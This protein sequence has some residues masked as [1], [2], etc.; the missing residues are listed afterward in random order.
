M[1]KSRTKAQGTRFAVVDFE[2]T[3]A[4]PGDRGRATEIGLVIIEDGQIVDQ[5]ESLMWTGAPI[6]ERIQ[7]L[8]GITP[9]MLDSAPKAADVMREAC[10]RVGD[11]CLIAHNAGFDRG[12]W[13]EEC[14]LAELEH[15]EPAFL[16]TLKLSRRIH[17]E[18]PRHALSALTQFH[19]ITLE[20]QAHRALADA[21]A[22]AQVWLRQEA[23][24]KQM[25][26]AAGVSAE[27]LTAPLDAALWDR[28][29]HAPVG[30]WWRLFLADLKQRPPQTA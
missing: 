8:T 17:A 20:G 6:P 3:G 10:A 22:T 15:P 28:V 30:A 21:K 7:A 11:A 19:G 13:L 9:H 27:A 4:G 14:R 1:S 2:T 12:F 23:R 25:A 18:A 24:L 29:Q 26:L 16:C 5:Y